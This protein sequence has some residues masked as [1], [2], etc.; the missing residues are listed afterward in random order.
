MSG[1]YAD[2]C[3]FVRNLCNAENERLEQ[4]KPWVAITEGDMNK[5]AETL[6]KAF[7]GLRHAALALS[8]VIPSLET[9]FQDNFGVTFSEFPPEVKVHKFFPWFPRMK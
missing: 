9:K 7:V 3:D 8:P 1:R 6:S 5:A 2:A 4:E